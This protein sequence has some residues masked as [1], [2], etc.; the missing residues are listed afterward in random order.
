VIVRRSGTGWLAVRQA[1]HARLAGE[2][3][4][5]A[6]LP[7]LVG[8]P[9]RERLL[10]AV[11]GHDNGWWEEDAAPRLD[12]ETGGPLD[13]RALPAAA[14]DAVWSRSVER[15]AESD[16]YV[17]ALVAGHFL[18]LAR[19]ASLA[20]P[21]EG[22]DAAAARRLELLERAEVGPDAVA[23][24]DRWLRLGDELSLVAAT[25]DEGFLGSPGW[26][27]RVRELADRTELAVEPFPWAGTTRFTLERRR[28]P[29]RRYDSATELGVALVAAPAERWPVRLVPLVP[30]SGG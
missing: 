3:V 25:L 26:R 10:R 17:A 2:I 21:P 23:E 30:P 13:F 16:P 14:R 19:S 22:L 9:R 7:E 8:H 20:P 12:P 11:A 1:D 29:A 4:G 27:C 28:I 15:W 5:L 6:R 24:D 18:R